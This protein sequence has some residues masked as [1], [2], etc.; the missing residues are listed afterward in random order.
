MV[1]FF[2]PT[3]KLQAQTTPV[4]QTIGTCTI[5]TDVGQTNAADCKSYG[6]TWAGPY[7]YLAPLPCDPTTAGPGCVLSSDGKT[8]TLTT[9]DPASQAGQSNN[10]IGDYLNVMIRI[11]IGLCAVLAVV[12]IVIGGIQYMTSELIS[13]KGEGKERILHA[14]FGL[15]LALGA[16]TLLNQINPD[17]LRTDLNSLQSVTVDV[18]ITTFNISSSG[19]QSRNGTA[20]KIDFDTQA[21]PAAATAQAKTGV[22]SALVLAIFN[23]ETSNGGNTGACFPANAN[24]TSADQT[25]LASIVGAENVATTHVSCSLSSGHG[26]AIGLTQFMPSTWNQYSSTAAT[27]LGHNPDPWNTNDA[28]MMT[29]V[30]LQAKGGATD[31]RQAACGYFGACSSGGVNYADQVVAK[32]ISVQKQIADAK[33]SGKIQ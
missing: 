19:P 18:P 4:D 15:L 29:A 5:G 28:L 3:Y 6:G 26:G 10:K 7:V 8:Y 14:I 21:Y 33:A 24:M 30:Y 17:I 16:W 20:I 1:G 27:Y 13:S 31:P 12:M 25:A 11:F 22:D 23:Q 2:S 32:M 9:F